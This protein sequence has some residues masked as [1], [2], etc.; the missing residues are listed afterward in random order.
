[1]DGRVEGLSV[2][3]TARR[4]LGQDRR[5]P[6]EQDDETQAIVLSWLLELYPAQVTLEELILERARD[7]HSFG[8]RDEIARAVQNLAGAGLVR[9]HGP[10]VVPTRAAVRFAELPRE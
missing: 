8:G 1:M 5:H 9:R 2:I 3:V 6:Q 4:R 7:P 10:F